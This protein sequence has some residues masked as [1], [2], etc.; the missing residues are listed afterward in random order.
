MCHSLLNNI[1]TWSR[2]L[3][4]NMSTAGL[5]IWIFLQSFLLEKWHQLTMD[6]ASDP[7]VISWLSLPLTPHIKVIWNPCGFYFQTVLQI[8]TLLP[9]IYHQLDLGQQH[10]LPSLPHTLQIGPCAPT[11]ALSW[12]SSLFSRVNPLAQSGLTTPASL[13]SSPQVLSLAH[14]APAPKYLPPCF[15]EHF[16]VSSSFYFLFKGT[17]LSPSPLGRLIP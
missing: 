5:W 9:T 10:P 8:Q 14:A 3:R 13:F 15:L 11:L 6:K 17:L 2:H 7:R 4:L 12:L 16:K 1:S